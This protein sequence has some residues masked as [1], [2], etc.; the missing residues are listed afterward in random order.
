MGKKSQH[1]YCKVGEGSSSEDS[2]GS[3]KPVEYLPNPS[4]KDRCLEH[5]QFTPTS[6]LVANCWWGS[7]RVG[8]GGSLSSLGE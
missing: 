1:R 2:T 7:G 3:K 5:Y 8:A 4:P 6:P